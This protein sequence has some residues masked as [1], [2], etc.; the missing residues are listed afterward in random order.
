MAVPVSALVS[1]RQREPTTSDGSPAP[2]LAAYGRHKRRRRI[3]IGLLYVVA[4]VVG[5]WLL[6]VA[7]LLFA[8]FI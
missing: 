4:L 5:G 1:Q 6:A 8:L 3:P 2:S 7:A